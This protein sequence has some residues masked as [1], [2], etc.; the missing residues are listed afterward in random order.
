[1]IARFV[2]SPL[3]ISWKY[4]NGEKST[5]KIFSKISLQLRWY[6]SWKERQPKYAEMVQSASWNK[7]YWPFKC[8]WTKSNSFVFAFGFHNYQQQLLCIYSENTDWSEISQ[9]NMGIF[10]E[11]QKNQGKYIQ[12]DNLMNSNIKCNLAKMNWYNYHILTFMFDTGILFQIYKI[13]TNKMCK[14]GDNN[15]L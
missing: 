8:N 4:S 3:Y 2:L 9:R 14:S 12:W 5:P 11:M 1:M 13:R 15:F 7:I 10:H 6:P